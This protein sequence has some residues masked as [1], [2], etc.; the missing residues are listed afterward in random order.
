MTN[1]LR[2][3]LLVAIILITGCSEK[4]DRL[5]LFIWSEYLD[6]NVVADFERQ[7]D[8]EVIIDYHEDQDSMLAKLAA[9]GDS[10]YDI[11]IPANID[12]PFLVNRGLLAP[13]RKEHIPNLKNID[14]KFENTPF[15]PGYQYGVPY[16][17]GTTG[18]YLRKTNDQPIDETWGLIFD[19]EKQP[20]PFILLE[21]M[22]ACFVAALRYKGYS[23]NTTNPK[24]LDEAA[25]LLIEAKK[26]SLGFEG[27]IGS[28]NRVLS[29]AASLAM[30][31]NVD[32]V[33]GVLQDAETHYFIPREG[34][35][36]YHDMLSIPAR[37]PHP[38]LAEK[39][40]NF[41]LDPKIGARNA[42]YNRAPTPNMAALEFV[43]PA[44]RSNP[45]IYPPSE[46]MSR[47]EYIKDV[48]EKTALY[49]ELWTRIK[50]R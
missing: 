26:R 47:L 44:D 3:L 24:E 21:D 11:V 9:G 28:R 38:E 42:N 50:S 2:H 35:I 37:A 16:L 43:N 6:P 10:I 31:Y 15:N 22:R 13:I 12:M 33:R 29:K 8:C 5:H 17:W 20:G 19:P 48:K 36:I 1:T 30:V 14:P 4:K 27:T 32:A 25:D 23:M 40:L 7:F 34:G 46:I 39:F 41:I 18:L 49:D 45:A